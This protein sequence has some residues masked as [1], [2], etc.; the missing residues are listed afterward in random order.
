M[1][2][3]NLL[4]TVRRKQLS[5]ITIRE[6]VKGILQYI[7]WLFYLPGL[8][9]RFTGKFS[10]S[11]SRQTGKSQLQQM[12]EQWWLGSL[13]GLKPVNYYRYRLFLPQVEKKLE[14]VFLDHEI[15]VLQ[16]YSSRLVSQDE[17]R[18]KC[19]FTKICESEQLPVV[20]I[21]HVIHDRSDCVSL[22]ATLPKSDLVIKPQF[23]AKSAG[24]SFWNYRNGLY[25]GNDQVGLGL[26]DVCRQAT[27]SGHPMLI[28]SR[29]R[30]SG[31][32][33]SH[34]NGGITTV[35]VLTG[36]Q[37]SDHYEV[38]RAV[39]KMPYGRSLTNNLGLNSAI[40]LSTGRL[41]KAFRY[42][43]LCDG[44]DAHPDTGEM[45]SGKRLGCW[46]DVME[47]ALNAHRIFSKYWFVGWD[48]AITDQGVKLLEGNLFWDVNML[49]F[50]YTQGLGKSS[51]PLIYQN[52]LASIAHD[53]QPDSVIMP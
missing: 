48:I 34:S 31:E 9:W 38:I 50:P 22:I 16:A 17:L 45:I 12:L 49:Q 44:Y 1:A 25:Q 41:A 43:A 35:R 2:L 42:Y 19:L 10:E 8:V 7:F 47:L 14:S 13:Y 51:F 52:C 15:K 30:N 29:L 40:N 28:Q 37:S 39:Y 53:D 26:F 46:S 11:V 32:T 33:E 4:D 18:D 27:A 20:T 3:V 24:I 21:E 6:R 5:E 36:K 23:G